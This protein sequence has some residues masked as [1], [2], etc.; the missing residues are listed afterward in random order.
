[1]IHV[2]FKMIPFRIAENFFV[3]THYAMFLYSI[4]S[5]IKVT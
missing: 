1:M 2:I 3:K 4:M 5:T